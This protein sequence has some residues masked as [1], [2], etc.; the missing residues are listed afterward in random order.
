MKSQHRKAAEEKRKRE[1][2]F[3]AYLDASLELEPDAYVVEQKHQ[4]STSPNA[5]HGF[6]RQASHNAG[7]YVCECEAVEPRIWIGTGDTGVSDEQ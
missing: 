6:A 1:E 2:A 4:C 3:N 7:R 5:V